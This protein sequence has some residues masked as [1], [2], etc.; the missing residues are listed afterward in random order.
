MNQEAIA[1]ATLHKPHIFVVVFDDLV[2]IK[3]AWNMQ[4]FKS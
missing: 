1:S 3:L 4:L 2:N